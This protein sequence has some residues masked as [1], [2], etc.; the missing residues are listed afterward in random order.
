M[1]PKL[2]R[3]VEAGTQQA[4]TVGVGTK[5]QAVWQELELQKKQSLL[6]ISLKQKEVEIST[7][8]Y[9]LLYPSYFLLVPP[10][11]TPREKLNGKVLGITRITSFQHREC[12][13]GRTGNGFENKQA[14]DS[15]VH[16]NFT[17]TQLLP[18]VICIQY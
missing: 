5:E 8:D 12:I 9:S 4:Q 1:S 3:H 10:S 11:S 13:R 15:K 2:R 14:N 16:I 6:K 17:K 7:L 18:S